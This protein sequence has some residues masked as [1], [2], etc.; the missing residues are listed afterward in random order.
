MLVL[1]VHLITTSKIV[2]VV[3]LVVVMIL[4]VIEK[5][6]I[7][8]NKV[9]LKVSAVSVMKDI[10]WLKVILNVVHM[11]HISILIMIYVYSLIERQIYVTIMT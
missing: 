8:L 5:L 4:I 1:N 6:L 3:S 9:K 7:V 11:E 10:G 2:S